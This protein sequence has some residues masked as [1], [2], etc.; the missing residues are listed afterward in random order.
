[1]AAKQQSSMPSNTHAHKRS[2]LKVVESHDGSTSYPES[3]PKGGC[4]GAGIGD[5]TSSIGNNSSTLNIDNTAFVQLKDG[6][7]STPHVRFCDDS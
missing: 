7:V 4:E 6:E 1:M 5:T 3:T 2:L